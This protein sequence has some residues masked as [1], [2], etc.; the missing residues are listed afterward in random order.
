M[1]FLKKYIGQVVAELKKVTWPTKKQTLNKTILVVVVS[2]IVALY[3]SGVDF[4]LQA[5]MRLLMN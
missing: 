5:L 4:V 3:I 2:A 1:N